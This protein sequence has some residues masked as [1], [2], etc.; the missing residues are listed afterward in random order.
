[1]KSFNLRDV[2]LHFMKHIFGNQEIKQPNELGALQSLILEDLSLQ[3]FK[4]ALLKVLP[5]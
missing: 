5:T 2:T 1:M 3:K 4:Q